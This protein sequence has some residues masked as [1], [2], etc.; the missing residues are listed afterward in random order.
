MAA[1]IRPQTPPP[2]IAAIINSRN[3]R[4]HYTTPQKA[5]TKGIVWWESLKPIEQRIPKTEIFKALNISRK[6]GYEIIKE[7]TDSEDSNEDIPSA[8]TS[9]RTFHNQGKETRG[10]KPLIPEHLAQKIE[11]I[12]KL[13]G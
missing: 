12:I 8:S 10:Q 6:R 13:C 3:P 2:S 11:D 9:V 5:I 7:S 4:G 1:Y